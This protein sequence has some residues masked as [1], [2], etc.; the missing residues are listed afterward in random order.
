[1]VWGYVEVSGDGDVMNG[2]L[3][4]LHGVVQ[5]IIWEI[6]NLGGDL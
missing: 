3:L 5:L 4:L 1:M 6:C 2:W